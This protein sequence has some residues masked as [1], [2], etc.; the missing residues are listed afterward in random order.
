MTEDMLAM[1]IGMATGRSLPGNSS[2]IRRFLMPNQP[3]HAVLTPRIVGAV[4]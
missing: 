2:P 1:P 4:L 3:Q